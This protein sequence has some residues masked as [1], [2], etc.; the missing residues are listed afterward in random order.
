MEPALTC[1]EVSKRYGRKSVL[2]KISL[3]LYPG[4]VFG[5]LGPNGAGK[6]TLIKSILGLVTPQAGAISIFGEDLFL[7]R[8][9]ALRQVGAVVEAP[10]FVETLTAREHL[11]C[12]ASL[13]GPVTNQQV[14]EVLRRV[15]LHDVAR[16]RIGTFSYGMKQRLGIAQAL[17]PDTRL[18]ILDEPTNGLDPHGIAG[19]RELIK[20]LTRD[21]GLSIFLSSHLLYEVEQVCDRFMIINHG[22]C[23]LSGKMADY[24]NKRS[25]TVDVVMVDDDTVY[26]IRERYDVLSTAPCH[27]PGLVSVTFASDDIPELVRQLVADGCRIEEVTPHVQSLEELFIEITRRGDE[28][29][30]MDF[31]PG[32]SKS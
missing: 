2:D 22:A 10:L 8:R 4:T 27:R 26:P 20:S 5:F 7:K 1:R 12:L 3:D 25:A 15:G 13:T 24:R 23:V 17:L 30:V 31:F 18:L 21:H 9:R 11:A 28:D 6:T 16:Q 14:E 29:A 19:M 32:G